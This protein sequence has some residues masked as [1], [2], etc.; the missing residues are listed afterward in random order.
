MIPSFRPS[1]C[2]L[3][4]SQQ[5]GFK[6]V[7]RIAEKPKVRQLPC[8][9]HSVNCTESPNMAVMATPRIT[10]NY[11][12]DTEPAITDDLHIKGVEPLTTDIASFPVQGGLLN[13]NECSV[14]CP[15]NVRK[16]L[17]GMEQLGLPSQVVRISG[18]LDEFAGLITQC[19]W[20][21]KEAPTDRGL[22]DVMNVPQKR[23]EWTRCEE[24]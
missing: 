24:T 2:I 4:R 9:K 13:S 8:L 15:Y 22:W 17:H 20:D 7:S 3:N 16:S 12:P 23:I 1:V 6:W 18:K 5:P 11:I 10:C 21:G 19:T 14:H